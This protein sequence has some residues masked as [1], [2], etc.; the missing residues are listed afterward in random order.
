MAI[1]LYDCSIPVLRG[2]LRNMARFL[3]KARAYADETGAAH[4]S[5]LEARLAGDMLS[6]VGQVQRATDTAKFMAVRVGQI[7]NLAM[8]DDEASFAELQ[9]RIAA[10]IAFLEQASPGAFADRDDAEVVLSTAA[11]KRVYTA[12]SYVL[13]FALPN[14]FFHVTTAYDLLRHKGV[15][16]GKRDYLGWR[17]AAV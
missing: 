11:G 5:L 2:G 6:L 3:E 13:E 9:S 7:P 4:A 17:D 15:P 10:T 12:R 1:S 8:A 14:F 16:L